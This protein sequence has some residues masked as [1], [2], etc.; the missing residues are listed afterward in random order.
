MGLTT[1]VKVQVSADWPKAVMW[2]SG[3]GL[4]HCASSEAYT[5]RTEQPGN[6]GIV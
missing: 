6:E 5:V 3:E 1:P 4:Q 2:G